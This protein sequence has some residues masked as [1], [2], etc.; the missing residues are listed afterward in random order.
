MKD[1]RN[2]ESLEVEQAVQRHIKISENSQHMN[3]KGW[4][5]LPK[6]YMSF[7]PTNLNMAKIDMAFLHVSNGDKYRLTDSAH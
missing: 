5:C 7:I 6:R 2:K 3:T 4:V 1:V